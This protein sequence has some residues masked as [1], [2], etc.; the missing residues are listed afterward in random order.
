MTSRRDWL[1]TGLA[2]LAELGARALT[3]EQLTARMGLTKGS[4]YHHFGGMAGYVTALLAHFEAEHTA[5]FIDI[6]EQDPAAP[7]RVRLQRLVDLV[8][9]EDEGPELETAIRSWALQN[10][11]VDAAQA[12][13]DGTRIDYL[14]GLWREISG[15]DGEAHDMA[16]LLY[17]LVVGAGHV[18]PP[19]PLA[20]V[21]TLYGLAL[22]WGSTGGEPA[23]SAVRAP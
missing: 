9:S 2:V 1:D 11:E 21:R 6:V 16:L 22:R 4:F 13:V 3:I 7:A 14:R 10:A 23:A 17:L 12:R 8:A 15:D 19:V 5:R 18:R 20:R